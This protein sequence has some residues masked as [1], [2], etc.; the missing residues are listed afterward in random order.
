MVCMCR[1]MCIYVSMTTYSS[2]Y[3]AQLPDSTNETRHLLRIVAVTEQG[4]FGCSNVIPSVDIL[5]V[6]ILYPSLGG[7]RFTHW[8]RA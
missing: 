3:A 4:S 5:G 2:L 8:Y 7:G 6:N 1:T